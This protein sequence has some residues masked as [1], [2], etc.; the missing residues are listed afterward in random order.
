M[1]EYLAKDWTYIDGENVLKKPSNRSTFVQVK[2]LPSTQNAAEHSMRVLAIP[3]MER[4]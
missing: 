1:M 2:T 3:S 4:G